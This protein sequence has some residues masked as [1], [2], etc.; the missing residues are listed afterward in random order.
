[1]KIGKAVYCQAC[2]M[3]KTPIGR[4]PP[5]GL[6]NS[7]CGHECEGYR[8]EP[9]PGSLWPGESEEEFGYPAGNYGIELADGA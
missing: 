9:R 7:L 1:M 8:K 2:G 4:S 3:R 5:L 6:A